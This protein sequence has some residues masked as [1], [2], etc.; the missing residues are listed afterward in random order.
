MPT[1]SCCATKRCTKR[2]PGGPR[3]A[4]WR[5]RSSAW[6][7]IRG[8][9]STTIRSAARHPSELPA[10]AIDVRG[11]P[12]RATRATATFVPA[13]R[14]APT[15]SA[16]TPR[17]ALLLDG[18]P[19]W[20]ATRA[21]RVSARRHVR[22]AQGDRGRARAQRRRR[23]AAERPPRRARSRASRRSCRRGTRA[24]SASSTRRSGRR[25]ALRLDRRRAASRRSTFVDRATGARAPY[26]ARRRDRA[27]RGRASCASAPS[28]RA[29]FA[30]RLLDA[31]FVPRGSDGFALHGPDRAAAFV[32]DVL[33]AWDDVDGALDPGCATLAGGDGDSTSPSRA[34]SGRRER[35]LVR[36]A[37]DV[38]VG[39]RRS[40][41]AERD[42]RRC[43]RRTG[44]TPTCAAS[45]S[46]SGGCASAKRCSPIWP[47]GAA[48]ASP[49][50]SRCATNCTR[51]SA[52]VAA[53]ATKWSA[54]R[55]AA[56]L[57]GHRGGRAAA[58]CTT[59]RCAA[60]QQR[61]L[62]FLAYLAAF[63]FGGVLADDMG[64][65]KTL[66]VIRYL[67]W[68][69][70]HEGAV[71]VARDRADVGDAH[72]GKRDRALR[73]RTAHAAAALG[74]RTRRALR[75]DR[76]ATTS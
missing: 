59:A 73:A 28:T 62:D 15:A 61:G 33:P 43:S 32:R 45:S 10:F 13:S 20:I 74:Q 27:A 69:K 18:P 26:A 66:Q 47:N 5:A 50:C 38:F 40:A 65:G 54:A 30:T 55:A 25:V 3:R 41:D 49:R 11:L 24:S 35:R 22:R 70:R 36:T 8:C 75:G 67:L 29:R 37:V 2:S 17:D 12:L 39:E 4:R 23:R 53:A 9:A 14:S 60:Y 48:A 31:G 34:S 7:A 56:R 44:A 21:R 72:V 19:A 64:L 63:G 42:A 52:S 58:R 76:R 51:T 71:A 68:R 57:R 46:T 16:S 6:R 1:A